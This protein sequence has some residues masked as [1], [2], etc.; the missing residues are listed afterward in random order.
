MLDEQGYV[1]IIDY[2]LSRMLQPDELAST[3]CGTPEYF[4]PELIRPG[5]Y[6]K[7]VDWWAIG[8]LIFEMLYGKTPFCSSR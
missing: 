8:I 2:G 6:G 3:F 1:K 5:G 4:A 7:D